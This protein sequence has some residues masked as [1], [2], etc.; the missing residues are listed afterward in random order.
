MLNCLPSALFHRRYVAS[1]SWVF[2]PTIFAT[3]DFSGA[4]SPAFYMAKGYCYGMM[5][6]QPTNDRPFEHNRHPSLWQPT[7]LKH[8]GRATD[9]DQQG[10]DGGDH[11]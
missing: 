6:M 7:P 4:S 8:A 3:A 2:V 10:P 11:A 1:I 9:N 5:T